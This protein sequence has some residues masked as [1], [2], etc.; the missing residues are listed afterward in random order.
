MSES[1]KLASH[2]PRRPIRG[3]CLDDSASSPLPHTIDSVTKDLSVW[4]TEITIRQVGL[5][6]LLHAQS[7]LANMNRK[8]NVH[9]LTRSQGAESLNA[10]I[11]H[12]SAD[13]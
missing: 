9:C 1:I 4:K 8:D 11:I 3:I 10:P 7:I 6:I 2:V 5:S 12:F 13:C